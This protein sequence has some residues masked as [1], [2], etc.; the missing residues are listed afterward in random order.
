MGLLDLFNPRQETIQAGKV[1]DIRCELHPMRLEANKNDFVDLEIELTNLAASDSLASI[2]ISVPKP[3]GLDASGFSNEKEIRL[4]QLNP[5]SRV[6]KKIRV[7]SNQRVDKGTYNI[8]IHAISHYNDY[9]HVL[10]ESRRAIPL[11]LV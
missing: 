8:T 7:Y 1:F 10:N 5:Q 3:L 6:A 4:G 9:S 11:R 2:L